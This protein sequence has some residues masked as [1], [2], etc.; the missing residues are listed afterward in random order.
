M[1][2]VNNRNTATPPPEIEFGL[3]GHAAMAL[4]QTELHRLLFYD[5][6]TDV[7]IKL[8]ICWVLDNRSREREIPWTEARGSA[9]PL[10]KPNIEPHLEI[11]ES[12]RP[13]RIYIFM[14]KI[15]RPRCQSISTLFYVF[16]HNLYIT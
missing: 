14:C 13:S 10:Q 7:L 15:T 12:V 5:R 9:P 1:E 6:I 4:S 11:C 2:A 3:S 16:Y 8:F